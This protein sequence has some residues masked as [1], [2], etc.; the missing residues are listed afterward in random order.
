MCKDLDKVTKILDRVLNCLI[1]LIVVCSLMVIG[2]QIGMGA[3]KS[4]GGVSVEM[5]VHSN[6]VCFASEPNYYVEEE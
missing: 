2:I 3:L 6:A 5:S 4:K 1:I